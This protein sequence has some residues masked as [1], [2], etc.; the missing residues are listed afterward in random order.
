MWVSSKGVGEEVGTGNCIREQ[1]GKKAVW[2]LESL[3]K[4]VEEGSGSSDL[5]QRVSKG[6][7]RKE[8]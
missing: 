8:T 3:V 6:V 2:H 7:L 1:P 5:C 4:T